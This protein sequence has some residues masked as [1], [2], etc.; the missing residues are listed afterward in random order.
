MNITL[1]LATGSNLG[2]RLNNL[3]LAYKKL[4]KEFEF[5]AASNIYLSK[6]LDYTKQPDF[7]NQ[8]LEFSIPSCLTPKKVLNI[9]QKTELSLGRKKNI[10]K[11]PRNIDIDILFYGSMQY[12]SKELVIPHPHLF[13]RSFVLNP[14]RELPY[15]KVLK[16]KW[17]FPHKLNNQAYLLPNNIDL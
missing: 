14:L 2:D 3:Q 8:V 13:K 15:Y 17:N 1:I 12:Q 7:Y 16:N 6:A 11:G 4:C 10:P 5:I 9:T